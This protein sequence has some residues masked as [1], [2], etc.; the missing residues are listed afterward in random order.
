MDKKFKDNFGKLGV[1]ILRGSYGLITVERLEVRVGTLTGEKIC[2]L[3]EF[4]YGIQSRN[5]VKENLRG[6]NPRLI[7]DAKKKF[8]EI[9]SIQINSLF[10]AIEDLSG[11]FI[12]GMNQS[13]EEFLSEMKLY[14]DLRASILDVINIK[15]RGIEGFKE[16]AERA[17]SRILA[18]KKEVE[19]K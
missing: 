19:M 14:D 18:G 7:A 2:L 10:L 3:K 15:S 5:G 9:V 13:T 6:K 12:G 8:F 1:G 4:T 11:I 17:K 16:L